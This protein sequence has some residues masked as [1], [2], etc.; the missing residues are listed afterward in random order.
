MAGNKKWWRSKEPKE[1]YDVVT[2]CSA[3]DAIEKFKHEHP[4]VILLDIR[5]PEM[6]G[7]EL[8]RRIRTLDQDVGIIMATAVVEDEKA[9]EALK[10]GAPDYI[11]KPFDLDYLKTSVLAKIAL[12][13]NK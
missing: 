2:S 8:M 4:N 11:I 12:Q 6:D 1:G 7:I 13:A 10:L 3:T 9:Q 5:M